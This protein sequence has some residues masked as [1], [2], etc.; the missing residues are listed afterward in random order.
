MLIVKPKPGMILIVPYLYSL[1]KQVCIQSNC[2]TRTHHIS[3]E[4]D[5]K[6]Y[7]QHSEGEFKHFQ[8]LCHIQLSP[9][10]V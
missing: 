6:W 7:S 1:L 4:Y 8:A 9:A 5:P 2:S 3:A 10:A